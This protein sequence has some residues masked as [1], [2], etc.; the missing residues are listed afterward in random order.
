LCCRGGICDVSLMSFQPQ[1]Y[2][3]PHLLP[4]SLPLSNDPRSADALPLFLGCVSFSSSS[5]LFF[6]ENSE[7]SFQTQFRCNTAEQNLRS[8]LPL[9]EVRVHHSIHWAALTLV[10]FKESITLRGNHCSYAR[11]PRSA[12]NSSWVGIR[13]YSS[14]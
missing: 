12:I 4:L 1:I 7:E 2:L 14:F 13:S 11:L 9:L 3:P 10:R 5:L 6:L 8:L